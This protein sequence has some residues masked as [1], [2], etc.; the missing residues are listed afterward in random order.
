MLLND[1]V[2][3]PRL[4]IGYRRSNMQNRCSDTD[5]ETEVLGQILVTVPLRSPQIPIGNEML[6]RLNTTIVQPM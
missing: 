5:G 6:E 1:T 4:H 3:L 2:N